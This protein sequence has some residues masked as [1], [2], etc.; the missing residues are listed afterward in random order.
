MSVENCLRMIENYQ[1]IND[2]EKEDR[3]LMLTFLKENED[4]FLR[5]NR[6]AHFTAS[7]WITNSKQDQVLLIHHNIYNAWTWSGG[8][9]DGQS[10]LLAV[11]LKEAKEETGL[12]KLKILDSSPISLEALTVNGHYKAGQW[13]PSHLHLNLTFLFEADPLD[14]LAIKA[15]ENSGVAWFTPQDAIELNLTAEPWFAE[16]IYPK[17]NARLNKY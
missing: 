15:D 13:V 12:S 8:H 1:P 4:A 5:S 16:R 2:Q 10:D 6:I 9:A 7:A 17:L 11:A 3:Q 14:E